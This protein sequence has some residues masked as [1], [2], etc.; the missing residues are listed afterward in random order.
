MLLNYQSSNLSQNRKNLMDSNK[1]I[2]VGS[3]SKCEAKRRWKKWPLSGFGF[4]FKHL[5]NR[6]FKSSV[7]INKP[8]LSFRLQP[9]LKIEPM[10]MIKDDNGVETKDR[11][12]ALASHSFILPY[13]RPAPHDK[14]NFL[15]PFPPL[16][17]PW[18]PTSL[19]KTLLFDNLPHNYYNIFW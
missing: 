6:G 17:A 12:F 19:H 16:G 13:S 2:H 8:K 18:S 5:N 11:V 4:Y 7:K 14:K 15:T 1:Q 9:H 3:P 10:S